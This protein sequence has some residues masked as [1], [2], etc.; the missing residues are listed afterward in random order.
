MKKIALKKLTTAIRPVKKVTVTEWAQE[1]FRLPSTSAEPGKFH[2]TRTPYAAEIMNAFTQPDIHKVAVK[3]AAQIGKALAVTTP[4]P[5]PE[6]FKTMGELQIGDKVF[7]ERG[8]ICNVVAVSEIFWNH[9]CYKLTFSD[10]AE[11]VADSEHLWQVQESEYGKEIGERVINTEEI[12]RNFKI[13]DRNRYAIPVAKALN[14]PEKVLPIDGYSLGA[15][16]GDGTADSARITLHENDIEIARQYLAHSRH[17]TPL[18]PAVKSFHTRLHELNLLKNKHIPKIYLRASY[19]QRLE[20]LRG[21]LD[22]D[23]TISR[24]GYCEITQKSKTLAEDIF[25]LLQ[26]LGLKPT[27]KIKKSICTNSP[28]C[29]ESTNY[30]IT[31][32]AYD[33]TPV[34]R[35][36]RKL[37]RQKSRAGCR[38][39]ETERR[40]IVNVEKVAS[41]P[42]KCIAVNSPNHLY[43]AGR[44]FIPTHNS[45][46][47]L[48]VIGRFAQ[49]DPC[50][51]MIIQPTL[52]M[53]QDFSK[54]RLQRM[55][56]DC[57]TLTPLFFDN[58]KT[59]NANQTILSKFFVGGRIVLQGANSP[60]GLASRPI[61]ILLCDE[62]DR[63]PISAGSEG[64]PIALAEKR[65]TTFFNYKTGIFS[66]PT[67]E[68]VSRIDVEYN[69]G[70]QE[71]WRHQCPNCGDWHF[72]N[73]RDMEV[74][75]DERVDEYKRRNVV[76]NSV[77]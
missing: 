62:I 75:Y 69:L 47:L 18:E 22:T 11:I 19:A 34:F 66:T 25:E 3:S 50:A 7:D 5:T 14:L 29:A 60:A 44:N 76:V 55:I 63:F 37:A 15:W 64:D 10:G 13:G 42:T 27:F 74:E 45:T 57:P 9:D 77:K 61:R 70:T 12:S 59:R 6:G 38:I 58:G 73:F 41:V 52:E 33:D 35:L 46:I 31:F 4:I 24:L 51:M 40:R 17:D 72:L 8:E 48:A 56:N 1:N 68:G 39:T 53:A 67:V 49:L 54:D 28:T 43:L 20:L 21:I 16:L 65:Q 2:V 32:L 30:R 26:T 36:Q 23:G 71:Q